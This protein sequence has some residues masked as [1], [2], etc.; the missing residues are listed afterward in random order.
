MYARGLSKMTVTNIELCFG[1][2]IARDEQA[3]RAAAHKAKLLE[4]YSQIEPHMFRQYDGFLGVPSDDVM[5]PDDDGD[6]LMGIMENW[7]LMTGNT[8]VRILIVP[9]TKKEDVLRLLEKL[10]E[11]IKK[12]YE[13]CEYCEPGEI[14]DFVEE[15]DI[16]F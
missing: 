15:N 5:Q 4:H 9:T 2:E 12:G 8:D 14:P 7:D 3:R 11:V 1:F 13:P 16:P 6:A 10:V